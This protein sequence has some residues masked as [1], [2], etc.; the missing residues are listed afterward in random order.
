MNRNFKW[1]LLSGALAL[2]MLPLACKQ[3]DKKSDQMPEAKGD[4]LHQ[5]LM[6][7]DYT[8]W[9]LWP[10]SKDFYEGTE[11]H[12]A[13]LTT[14]VNGKALKAIN[15][16]AALPDGSIVVKENYSPNK[17][18]AA[19]TVMYKRAGFDADN[20]DWFWLKYGPEGDVQAEGMVDGCINCH[21][22][23]EGEDYLFLNDQG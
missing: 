20:D 8:T 2:L 5:Y 14:Y 17:E 9:E 19:V 11:P 4:A 23:A 18:L 22:D 15:D 12:G 16:G 1:A 6:D 10:G 21:N 7:E 13:L 3:A